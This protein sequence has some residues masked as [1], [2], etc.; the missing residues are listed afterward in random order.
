MGS[1]KL[2]IILEIHFEDD[3]NTDDI[4]KLTDR[5]QSKVKQVLNQDANV[6]VE[7]ES[8]S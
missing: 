7:V 3:I 6:V 1:E 8:P 4:E 2:F 5:I